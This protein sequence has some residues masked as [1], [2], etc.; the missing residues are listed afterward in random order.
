MS[1]IKG[2]GLAAG[3]LGVGLYA[4]LAP[5][6][7]SPTATAVAQQPQP[8]PPPQLPSSDDI[9]NNTAALT[10]LN[11]TLIKADLPNLPKVIEGAVDAAFDKYFGKH[12]PEGDWHPHPRPLIVYKTVH[13][14]RRYVMCCCPPWWY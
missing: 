8:P 3:F 1:V 10:A 4:V 7:I 14:H 9:R 11:N 2:L 6:A 12:H 13:V 5:T